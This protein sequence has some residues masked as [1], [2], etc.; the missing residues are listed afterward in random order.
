MIATLVLTIGLGYIGSKVQLSYDF[1]RAIP[2]DNPKYLA[3]LDFKKTFGEDGNL[4]TVGF[5]TENYPQIK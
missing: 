1:S 4:L 5:T 2:T 3:Y